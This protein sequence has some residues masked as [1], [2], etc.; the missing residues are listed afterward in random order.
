VARYTVG[1]LGCAATSRP[2]TVESVA[3]TDSKADRPTS[4]LTWIWRSYLRGA[5]IPLICIELVLLAVYLASHSINER[6]T[7]DTFRAISEE[8]FENLAGQKAAV[9]SERLAS[10]TAAVE[11]LRHHAR[12]A[13]TTTCTPDEAEVA[14]YAV[15][16]HGVFHTRGRGGAA[17]YYS[18][19]T[20]LG[21]EE[22]LKAY[23]SARLDELMISLAQASPLIDQIYV[24]TH[25]SMNRIYP[26]FDV[27]EQYISHMDIPSFNFYYEADARHNPDRDVVW[28]ESYLDPA[29]RGW[30]VSAVAPVYRN[31]F[32][33][34][35]VGIDVTL[36]TVISEVLQLD[37]P[38]GSYAMLVGR[39]GRILALPGSAAEEWRIDAPDTATDYGPVLSNTWQPDDLN[40]FARP[41]LAGLAERLRAETSG[42]GSFDLGGAR[43]MT[44]WSVVGEPGW[45]ILIVADERQVF[46][47]VVALGDDFEAVG[48]LMMAVL[49]LFS[50]GFFWA[51]YSRARRHS[52][53][54]AEPLLALQAMAQRIGRGDFHQPPVTS[55]IAELN[56]TGA[57]V[58]RMGNALGE[59]NRRLLDADRELRRA[60]VDARAANRAKSEFLAKMSHELRTPLNAI[61]GFSDLIADRSFGP[62]TNDR[63]FEYAADIRSS[64]RH[65][66]GLINDVLDLSKIEAG[67]H[68]L[69]P[70]LLPV[71]EL[72]NEVRSMVA[73]EADSRGL[74]LRV[75]IEP[76]L[77]ALCADPRA[78]R[79]VL[80]N[81]MSNAIKFTSAGGTITLGSAI[82]RPGRLALWVEDEGIGIPEDRLED[83]LKPFEQVEGAYARGHGGTGL[84]LT[85]VK[86]LVELHG[87]EVR[88]AS[89]LGQGTR[90]TV[91]FPEREQPIRQR[92]AELRQPDSCVA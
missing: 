56:A 36:S 55:G 11:V 48:W 50:A 51:L 28:T 78:A 3:M 49:V 84:G 8:E 88:I 17:L 5:L 64:G 25:D 21:P 79:Q 62:D 59:A 66:L 15:D 38:P 63:Y 57:E 67:Q 86:D 4:L 19:I 32:L 29:G 16:E 20:P 33:E 77:P 91:C 73:V 52:R 69:S 34:A 45:T 26:W 83:V 80:L 53:T 74:T 92:L 60:L 85:I 12:E 54:I 23:C 27:T 7:L 39:G 44:A 58:A 24:N 61:I 46:A 13:L 10:V 1:S 70:R 75:E 43:R 41:G 40:L 82:D 22:R 14:R 72:F 81:L 2:A 87:G 68:E 35:V 37:L 71:Q 18:A 9:V 65:L 6:R 76:G 31:D 47:E 90:V 30:M 42:S 89:R